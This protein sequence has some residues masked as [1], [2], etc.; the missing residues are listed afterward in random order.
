MITLSHGAFDARE[1]RKRCGDRS[2]PPVRSEALRRLVKSGQRYAYDLIVHVALGRYIKGQQRDEIRRELSKERGIDLSAGTVSAL[3]DRF[4]SLFEALHVH[5]AP[6]LR[7]HLQQGGYPL[8]LDATCEHGKGGLFLCMDGWRGWTL[9]G[10]RVPSENADHLTSVVDRTVEL[11]G[12]PVA[13]MRDMGDGGAHA[14]ERLR[15]DGVPDLI[16]HYHFAGAVGSSLF[17]KLYDHLRG[18]LRLCR[19]RTD[20][21]TLLRELRP[22][23]T[24]RA[25]EGRWG[26]GCVRE[27][28]KALVLWVLEGDGRKDVPYPFALPHLEFVRRC[29]QAVERAQQWVP[30][31]RTQ[32]ERRVI[33]VLARRVSRLE[34]DPRL[35]ATVESLDERW[36]TFSELRGVL[37]LSDADL[38]RGDTRLAPRQL[39]AL[40]WLR[41]EQIKQAVESF[42][43]ELKERIPPAE[44]GKSRPSSAPAIVL[45][46]LERNRAHLFGHPARLD[47][48]GRVVAVVARTNNVIE[49]FFGKD[50]QRLRRRVGRAHL[51]QD[52]EQQPAQVALVSNLRHAD[53]VQVLCGSLDH[54]PTALAELDM[55]SAVDPGPPVRDQRDKHLQQR[56]RKLLAATESTS[57][58]EA[59]RTPPRPTPQLEPV[60]VSLRWPELEALSEDELRARCVGVFDPP[61]QP[62]PRDPRAAPGGDGAEAPLPGAHLP[63]RGDGGGIRVPGSALH[64]PHPGRE[65]DHRH[66][67]WRIPV[68]RPEGPLGRPGHGPPATSPAQAGPRLA[69]GGRNRILT[70]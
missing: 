63:R 28:L 19:V 32:P 17:D 29:R 44:H 49:H 24:S 47:P 51:G 21:R 23:N 4:L 20:L 18:I 13:T 46:Y 68:L 7:A 38:P 35:V 11:F 8:H 53:Y 48:D 22:Y 43:A 33:E 14:V 39:P 69:V 10:A 26:L 61:P 37:R 41:L 60:D 2:C 54:L 58:A 42:E 55:Q 9:W 40:E 65:R 50:K 66:H 12:R 30:C 59:N 25:T 45:K 16:C 34:R 3:C 64:A 5:R 6:Q 62:K 56:V 52:L 36:R 70:R 67:L 27:D 57:A 31:P 1:I 15:K